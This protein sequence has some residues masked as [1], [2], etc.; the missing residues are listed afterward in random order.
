MNSCPSPACTHHRVR[1][2]GGRPGARAAPAS[3][4]VLVVV[5]L[6]LLALVLAEA[7]AHCAPCC[8]D[9]WLG[10][11]VVRLYRRQEERTRSRHTGVRDVGVWR[12]ARGAGAEQ[13]VS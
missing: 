11:R 7:V 9:R 1:G 6:A 12:R 5:L 4:I 8:Y 2:S 13:L 10:N 3:P